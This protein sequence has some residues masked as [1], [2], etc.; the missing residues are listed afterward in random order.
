[1]LQR[2]AASNG[3]ARPKDQALLKR[4][5]EYTPS[6]AGGNSVSIVAR[7][8]Q[9]ANQHRINHLSARREMIRWFTN[10]LLHPKEDTRSL[11]TPIARTCG[12]QEGEILRSATLMQASQP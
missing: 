4:S 12:K 10:G 2:N 8:R 7:E 1:M 9:S 11:K 5:P 6:F 3:A